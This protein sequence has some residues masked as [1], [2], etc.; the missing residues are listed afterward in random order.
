M[1]RRRGLDEVVHGVLVVGLIVSIALFLIG[2]G[3]DVGQHKSLPETAVTPAEA[4]RRMMALHPSGFLSLGLMILLATPVVRVIGSTFVFLW[5]RDW[6]Y[7]GVTG[8]VL[9]VMLASVLLGQR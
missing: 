9:A 7:A 3:L 6:R 2:L 1:K 4:I 8:F 5:R